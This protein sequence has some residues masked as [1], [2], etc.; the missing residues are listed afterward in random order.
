MLRSVEIE[1]FRCF[2]QLKVSGFERLSLIISGKNN[3]AKTALLE[4][5]QRF[6]VD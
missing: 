5:I 2:D 6:R 3:I 4:A 1:N